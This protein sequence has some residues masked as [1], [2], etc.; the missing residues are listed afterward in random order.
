M[1]R[2]KV[3][4]VVKSA[5]TSAKVEEQ[6]VPAQDSLPDQRQPTCDIAV[7]CSHDREI[8]ALVDRMKGVVQTRAAGFLVRTGT[9]GR[10]RIVV[11]VTKPERGSVITNGVRQIAEAVIL[12]HEPTFV[13]AIGF[14]TALTENLSLLDIVIADKVAGESDEKISLNPSAAASSGIS[15]GTL[16]SLDVTLKTPGERAPLSG[17]HSAIAADRIALPVALACQQ[18]RVPMLALHVIT[19]A[20]D[21]ETPADIDHLLAQKSIAGRTGALLG[22]LFRRP[23]VAGNLWELQKTIWEASDRLANCL[24]KFLAD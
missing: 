11:A 14:A 17:K 4:D 5:V 20:V 12:A 1:L 6:A 18:H 9:L 19:T 21:E 3:G 8:T 16:L 2:Q 23:G 7:I 10:K 15:I 24:T 22:G 13:A